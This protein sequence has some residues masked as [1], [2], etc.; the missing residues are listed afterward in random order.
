ML[1]L[2]FAGE[3]EKYNVEFQK[4]GKNTVKVSGAPAKTKGFYLSR[5]GH[6]DKWDY[7]MYNTVY[8]KKGDDVIYSRD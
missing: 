5:K 4:T 1:V 7:T 8:E 2:Q 6:E 3:K